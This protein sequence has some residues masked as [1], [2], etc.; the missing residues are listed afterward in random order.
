[1][2][3]H[4]PVA[5]TMIATL[6][7]SGTGGS[8]PAIP[9]VVV[10]SVRVAEGDAGAAP[11]EARVSI[12]GAPVGGGPYVVDIT[13]M[14][15]S[16]NGDDFSFPPVRLSFNSGGPPQ[17]V[18]GLIIGD[19]VFEDDEA[20][21]LHV[22]QAPGMYHTVRTQ[23]GVVTIVDDDREKAPRLTFPSPIQVPEGNGGWHTVVI[24]VTLSAPQPFPV[25]FDFA[26]SGGRPITDQASIDGDY[27][28]TAGSVTLQ[29]GETRADLPV[30]IFGDGAWEPDAELW[31]TLANVKGAVAD[32]TMAYVSLTNDDPPTTV[33]V[34]D[35]VAFE[36]S[37][38][39]NPALLS[40]KLSAPASGAGKVWLKLQGGSALLGVDFMNV[41]AQVLTP[42]AG[43]TDLAFAVDVLGDTT[44]ECD[45]GLTIEYRSYDMGEDT[46]LRTARLLIVDDDGF[47]KDDPRC[48]DP[49]V[50]T[51]AGSPIGRPVDA[52]TAPNRPADG[53]APTSPD[54]G[55]TIDGDG[56]LP[57]RGGCCSVA[58]G[59]STTSA[60]ASLLLAAAALL[61][62]RRRATPAR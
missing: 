10:D 56:P 2:L 53:G 39:I 57:S 4:L 44:P 37:P 36:G 11:F 33:T 61:A 27:R 12:V 54:G 6:A 49:Y 28:A 16:A 15:S 19:P 62:R 32:F 40:L 30:E 50:H 31:M 45:E 13:T 18:T 55:Q 9:T 25:T 3:A 20:F 7:T 8:Y 1:M 38:G 26:T 51:E 5:A 29:P 60:F 23:D 46:T 59:T 17:V 48:P 43:A 52:G 35:A 22:E 24:P 47:P 21:F 41:G 42:P 14:P 58:S 34:D